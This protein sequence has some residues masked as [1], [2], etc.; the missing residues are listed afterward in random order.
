VF[1]QKQLFKNVTF[2][3]SAQSISYLVP[4]LT[5][6]YLTRALGAEG[7]GIYSLAI[8]VS[9]FLQIPMEYGFGLSASRDIAKAKG[10]S[11]IISKLFWAVTWTKILIGLVAFVVVAGVILAMPSLRQNWQIN[12]VAC[13][14]SACSA[15]F[16]I[17]LL[18]GLEKMKGLASL[19]VATKIINAGFIF[20]VISHRED[21]LKL[22][23]WTVFVNLLSAVLGHYLAFKGEWPKLLIP[24]RREIQAQLVSGFSVFLSQLG[25]LLY[26]NTNLI[27]LSIWYDAKIIGMYA[28]AEKIMRAAAMMTYAISQAIYPVSSK[29]FANSIQEGEVFL[30]RVLAISSPPILIG[31]VF[32]CLAAPYIVQLISG[33][34]PSKMTGAINALR[35]LSILPISIFI[36]N[37]YGSQ[38]LLAIGKDR[39]YFFGTLTSGG[40]AIAFQLILIPNFGINGA[41]LS[42]VAAELGL[43]L[44]YRHYA[45]L[46]GVRL[47]SGFR[48]R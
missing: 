33:T 45:Q 34:A 46:S 31:C 29:K 9:G 11:E 40:V 35:L 16:P 10:N 37:M 30:R 27:M 13:A 21:I 6:P 24:S 48:A 19:T 26:A 1:W 39:E 2:L 44:F 18:Q 8:T 7:F 4:L 17:W 23:A 41:A 25:F 20:I 43:L 36:C 38:I 3:F 47:V 22:V 42:L 5:F 12:M 15:F 14:S 32:L 28:I